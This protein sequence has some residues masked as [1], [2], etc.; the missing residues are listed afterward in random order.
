MKIGKPVEVWIADD[1]GYVPI[2]IE[3]DC[4]HNFQLLFVKRCKFRY[5]II[6]ITS[7]LLDL[8]VNHHISIRSNLPRVKYPNI[9]NKIAYYIKK[10]IKI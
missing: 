1:L 2:S 4:Y 6:S 3:Q 8:Y 5:S 10:K 7:N 9:I